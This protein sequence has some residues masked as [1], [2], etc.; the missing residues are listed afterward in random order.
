M[1]RDPWYKRVLQLSFGEITLRKARYNTDCKPCFQLAKVPELKLPNG[2]YTPQGYFDTLITSAVYSPPDRAAIF[3]VAVNEKTG[4]LVGFVAGERAVGKL[5]ILWMIVTSPK[6][7]RCGIGKALIE[8]FEEECNREYIV[9]YAPMFNKATV[10]FYK[11]VGYDYGTEVV[12]F[13][14]VRRLK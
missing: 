9:L 1:K 7:R 4:K 11:S 13:G 5:A 2:K 8:A 10:E 3:I 6:H 12:E 14:K